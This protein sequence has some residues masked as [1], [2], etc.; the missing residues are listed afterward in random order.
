MKFV[1]PYK[2]PTINHS[3]KVYNGKPIKT[4]ATREFYDNVKKI[5][6]EKFPEHKLMLG[7]LKVD[8][9]YNFRNA[10]RC[11]VDNYAKHMLDSLTGICWKD[12]KQIYILNQ[13][14]KIISEKNQTD[15]VNL[16]ISEIK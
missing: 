10:R 7:E 16:E 12:D 1:I 13:E 5:F 6:I 4:K 11:D 9:I 15:F 3:R 8:I 14:K 2:P